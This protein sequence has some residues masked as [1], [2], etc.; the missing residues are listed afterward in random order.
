MLA[1][2]VPFCSL[3]MDPR[4]RE[5]GKKTV[6]AEHKVVDEEKKSHSS[7]TISLVSGEG[8]FGEQTGLL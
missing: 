3:Y 6:E 8:E 2:A 1:H 4:A 5:Q 7:L